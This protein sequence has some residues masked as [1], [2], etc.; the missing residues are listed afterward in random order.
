MKNTIQKKVQVSLIGMIL[1]LACYGCAQ[2]SKESKARQAPEPKQASL[3]EAKPTTSVDTTPPIEEEAQPLQISDT[4]PPIEEEAQP[5]QSS[6][7]FVHT[8]RW[9]R[10]TLSIIAKW[11]TGELEN[12]KALVKAN[13]KLK[14]N[15]IYIGNKILIPGDLLKTRKPMPR[16]FLAEFT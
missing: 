15:R 12:W 16:K 4:T 6:I 7:P 3:A 10:E 11:Y 5:L 1:V 13:P 2:L 8:V 14:P 9:P